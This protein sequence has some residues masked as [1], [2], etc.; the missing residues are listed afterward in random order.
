M[1]KINYVVE[2]HSYWEHFG[3]SVTKKIFESKSEALEAA[4]DYEAKFRD[5]DG[6]YADIF[7]QK[8]VVLTPQEKALHDRRIAA[9][10]DDFNLRNQTDFGLVY[11]K[12][13]QKS[14]Y[15]MD[16]YGHHFIKINGQWYPL[17]WDTID[18][19]KSKNKDFL[20]AIFNVQFNVQFK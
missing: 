6:Y 14:I 12:N 3:A 7:E 4:L 10:S 13:G 16:S 9:K 17:K 2:Y 20:N 15:Y 19:L 18:H 8:T 11:F 1:L 5:E